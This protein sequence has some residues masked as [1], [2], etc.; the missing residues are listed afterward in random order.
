MSSRIAPLD[1]A[2][3]DATRAWG[4]LVALA[5]FEARFGSQRSMWELVADKAKAVVVA[6]FKAKG[7]D[8]VAAAKR[9]AEIVDAI[10]AML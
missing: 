1:A 2:S 8:R 7:L 6:L 10:V 5:I 4:S 3:S 9:I